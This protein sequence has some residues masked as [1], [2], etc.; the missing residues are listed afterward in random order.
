MYDLFFEIQIMSHKSLAEHPNIV[1][2]LGLSF[3]VDAKNQIYPILAVEAAHP[4]NP[5]LMQFVNSNNRP[6]PIPLDLIYAL[7]GDIAEGLTA[8]H[9]LGVV[10]Y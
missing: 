5:D 2:L 10:R 7:M 4:Q 1:K 8:L 6:S 3:S 9:R